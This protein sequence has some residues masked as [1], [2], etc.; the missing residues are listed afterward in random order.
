M[1]ACLLREKSDSC[2]TV[3]VK[4]V[5]CGGQFHKAVLANSGVLLLCWLDKSG[6]ISKLRT[7]LRTAFPGAPP[8]QAII[9]HTTL[10]RILTPN[11]LD[12]ATRSRIATECSEWSASFQGEQVEILKLRFLF[13]SYT[14]T[15]VEGESV[16][17]PLRP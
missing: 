15:I 3:L 4:A 16:D 9:L 12:E 8:K 14:A 17:I 1:S 5:M 6:T 13:N 11:Q 10:I 2:A 7:R